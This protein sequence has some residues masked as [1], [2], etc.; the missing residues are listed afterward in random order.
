MSL[1]HSKGMDRLELEILYPEDVVSRQDG[2][3][4]RFSIE[5]DDITEGKL[6]EN[7]F[8]KSHICEP[9]DQDSLMLVEKVPENQR[10]Y[11][12]LSVI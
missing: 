3:G 4:Y 6:Q 5:L 7:P 8:E 10:V 1:P 2:R 9:V 11:F 12:N